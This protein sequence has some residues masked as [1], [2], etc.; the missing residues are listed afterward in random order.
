MSDNEGANV[1]K[2]V[3]D[4]QELNNISAALCNPVCRI[5][6]VKTVKTSHENN[7]DSI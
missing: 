7:V 5:V 3:P 2:H 6:Q 1:K 4:Y